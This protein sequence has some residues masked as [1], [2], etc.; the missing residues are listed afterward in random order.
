MI[1]KN[2]VLADSI[3]N[4]FHELGIA[5]I[6]MEY[7]LGVDYR[8]VLNGDITPDSSAAQKGFVI[9]GIYQMLFNLLEGNTDLMRRWMHQYSADLG[10]KPYDL[11]A[12]P[13]GMNKL[14]DYLES[15]EK[16]TFFSLP[17]E[18]FTASA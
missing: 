7:L 1:Q 6:E 3:F 5:L 17:S 2:N 4:S 12:K 10:Y 13:A 18:D 16:D 14:H 11:L 15:C 9:I 8:E